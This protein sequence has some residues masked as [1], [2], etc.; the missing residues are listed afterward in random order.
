M[1]KSE[2]LTNRRYIKAG[3]YNLNQIKANK[4]YNS[5]KLAKRL[6]I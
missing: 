2:K 6:K 4:M 3:Q 1:L 5:S